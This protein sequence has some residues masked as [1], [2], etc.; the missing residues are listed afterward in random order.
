M[1]LVTQSRLLDSRGLG[2]A[3]VSSVIGSTKGSFA[4]TV[5]ALKRSNADLTWVQLSFGAAF[6]GHLS[7]TDWPKARI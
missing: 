2:G 3:T 7:H 4:A 6:L 5:S 1:R